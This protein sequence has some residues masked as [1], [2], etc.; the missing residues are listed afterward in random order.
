MESIE[1]TEITS[2][3]KTVKKKGKP[4]KP[5]RVSP[6]DLYERKRSQLSPAQNY[7]R[8]VLKSLAIVCWSKAIL[9]SA[10]MVL[11]FIILCTRALFVMFMDYYQVK[12]EA[13]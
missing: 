12:T 1:T 8:I 10:G 9:I 7:L 11:L 6:L 3:V 4:W 5:V 2:P 13:S